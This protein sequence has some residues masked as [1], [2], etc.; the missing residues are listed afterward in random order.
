MGF[1]KYIKELWK[2]PKDSLGE[3]WKER[4]VQWR[5]EPSVIRIKRPTRLDRARS[6]GYKPKQGIVLVRVRV[7]R[8][9]K[10]RPRI[11][12]GRRS[13]HYHQRLTLRKS[14]QRI[15]EERANRKFPNLEVLNSYYVADDG[16]YYWYEVILVDKNHP[17]IRSDK[18]LNWIAEKQHKGRVFRGLT[19]AGKK[20]R[21]LRKKGKGTEKL[22]PSKHAKYKKKT[23]KQK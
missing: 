23:K 7:R 19:S 22:R 3:I 21:G 18:N 14:Y 17:V 1:Y 13:K 8:G 2:R 9:G 5:K 20:N 10:K 6:L 16:L 15:C 11:A 12:K 4:L